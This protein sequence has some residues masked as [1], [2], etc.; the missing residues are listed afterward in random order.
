MA[1]GQA[2]MTSALDVG[3]LNAVEARLLQVSE[4]SA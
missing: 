3:A 2:V 1:V 4:P